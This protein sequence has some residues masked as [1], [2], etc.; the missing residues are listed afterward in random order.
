M[1]NVFQRIEKFMTYKE[2][3]SHM[4]QLNNR[5]RAI[6]NDILYQNQKPYKTISCFSNR[7]YMG[8]ENFHPHVYYIKH[9]TTLY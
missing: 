8:K 6:V 9:V 2:F 4:K 7:W 3:S 5:Q 1:H